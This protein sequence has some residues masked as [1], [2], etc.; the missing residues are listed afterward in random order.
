MLLGLSLQRKLYTVS[1][2]DEYLPAITFQKLGHKLLVIYKDG[3]VYYEG[4]STGP[5][6]FA[7]VELI[8]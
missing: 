3:H 5:Y 1:D 4:P 2:E 8:H 6:L 7:T